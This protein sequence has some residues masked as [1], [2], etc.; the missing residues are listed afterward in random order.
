MAGLH[1]GGGSVSQ[2]D[3]NTKENKQQENNKQTHKNTMSKVAGWR[4]EAA[5]R[6][7]VRQIALEGCTTSSGDIR[8]G[9]RKFKLYSM[10]KHPTTLGP[11]KSL[12]P[13]HPAAKFA[14]K[15]LGGR[16]WWCFWPDLEE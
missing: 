4:R 7:S 11:S 3:D 1:L 2:D 9:G 13:T 14:P 6:T 15:G 16:V 10:P 8:F 12:A 5:N